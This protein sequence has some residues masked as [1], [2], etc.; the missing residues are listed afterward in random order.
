MKNSIIEFLLWDNCNNHCKFCFLKEHNPCPSF[1]NNKERIDSIDSVIDFIHTQWVDGDSIL[2]C[3][4]ELFDTPL[5]IDLATHW[6]NLTDTIIDG[7]KS[8]KISEIYINTNLIY[9]INLSLATFLLKLA[10]NGV[11]EALHF[12]TSFD[13]Y[14]RFKSTDDIFLFVN[15]IQHLKKMYPDLEIVVNVVMTKQLCDAVYSGFDVKSLQEELHIFI[16]LI[17]YIILT[18]NM[19]PSKEQVMETIR[20]VDNQ[21]PGYLNSM[22]QRFIAD[23]PRK[24]YKF[25]NGRLEY[26]TANVAD[27][28]HSEN[29]QRYTAD[30]SC[31]ICDLKKLKEEIYG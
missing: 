1:L 15:N 9:D 27:C 17:P 30:G 8:G 18:E 2:L 23:H 11:L 25:H 24:L 7:V 3:G 14:G 21:I 20:I 28:G 16:N 29:F 19:A 26:M 31:F 6:E 12:T 10:S 22:V 4:G 13:L 5:T